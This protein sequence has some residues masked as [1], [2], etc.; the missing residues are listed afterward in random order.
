MRTLIK[1]VGILALTSSLSGCVAAAVGAAAASYGAVGYSAYTTFKDGDVY[2]E[3]NKVPPEPAALDRI[4]SARSMVIWPVSGGG[5]GELADILEDATG[6][7]IA[8]PRKVGQYARKRDIPANS[9]AL[10]AR[11]K[12][13]LAGRMGRAFKADMVLLSELR[14]VDVSA[15][16]FATSKATRNYRVYLI[17][18]KNGAILWQEDARIISELTT[19]PPSPAEITRFSAQTLAKRLNELRA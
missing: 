14:D 10:R 6:I 4:R 2:V 15:A 5:E 19:S 8:S 9:S 16:V 3:L 12:Q 18:A 11:E 1:A 17:D 13:D 7:R